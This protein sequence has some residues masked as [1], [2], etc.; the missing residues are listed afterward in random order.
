MFG[1]TEAGLL[2]G[3]IAVLLIWLETLGCGLDGTFS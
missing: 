1:L 2:E 3:L